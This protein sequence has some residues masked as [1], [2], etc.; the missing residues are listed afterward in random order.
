MATV[1]RAHGFRFVIF[2]NDHSPPHVHVFGQGGEAKIVLTGP[3]GV[4]LDWVAGISRG[5]LR[6]VMQEA[7]TERERLIAM[8]RKIHER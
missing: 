2:T 3:E 1:H 4:T 7:R 8:W 6:R 5:D